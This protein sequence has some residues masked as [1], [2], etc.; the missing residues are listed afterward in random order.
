MGLGG[1]GDESKLGGGMLEATCVLGCPRVASA[2]IVGQNPQLEATL[3]RQKKACSWETTYLGLKP[4]CTP[5]LAVALG[6]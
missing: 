1:R 2:G 4:G 5:F 6:T 3:L